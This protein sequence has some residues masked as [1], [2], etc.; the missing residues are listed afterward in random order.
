MT[1]VLRL[2]RLQV[3]PGKMAALRQIYNAQIIPAIRATAGHHSSHLMEGVTDPNEAIGW[4]V[5]D[6]SEFAQAYVETHAYAGHVAMVRDLLTQ[7][8]TM[9]ASKFV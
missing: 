4:I 5:W 1:L 8:P 6:N 9:Q 7:E 2:V 3:K